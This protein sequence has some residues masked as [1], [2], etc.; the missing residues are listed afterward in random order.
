MKL[1]REDVLLAH[2]Q[3]L[4]LNCIEL[5]AELEDNV[6]SKQLEL[7]STMSKSCLAMNE[8]VSSRARIR[9]AI[10]AKQDE[11]ISVVPF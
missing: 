11:E 8:V 9:A 5:R 3:T 6:I 10:A 7:I 2:L 4:A 1:S